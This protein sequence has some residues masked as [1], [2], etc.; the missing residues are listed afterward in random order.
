MNSPKINVTNIIIED[1]K[2]QVKDKSLLQYLPDTLFPSKLTFTVTPVSNAV[3]N[4]IRRTIM[5]ELLVSALHANI[6]DVNTNDPHHI[7]EMITQRL[8]TIPLDQSA[9][10]DAIFELYAENK[11]PQIRDVKSGEIMIISPGRAGMNDL[12]KTYPLKKLPFNKTFTLMTLAPGRSIRISGIGITQS[13]G[14][15][16]GDGMHVLAT[17]ATSI[18]QDQKP[19]NL[20][21][22]TQGGI[23]SRMSNPRVYTISFCTNGSIAPSMLV[24]IACTNIIARLGNLRTLL[25]LIQENEKE[26]IMIV[27]GESDTIGNLIMRTVN[28]LYPDIDVTYSVASVER[29]LTIRIRTNEDINRV[30]DS[31]IKHLV[32]IYS[33]IRVYFNT[34]H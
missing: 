10:I 3:S 31:V 27:G 2:P 26:Y 33:D 22:P 12:V 20:Y 17:S 24:S 9:P 8:Q 5:C 16:S 7:H 18:P 15:I 28:D 32:H 34:S 30:Y 25:H 23:P 14:F 6:D 19:I 29:R 4:G 21:E 11:T 13:Y 1:L